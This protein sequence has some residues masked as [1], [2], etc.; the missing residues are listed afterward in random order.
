MGI[1]IGNQEDWKTG[2]AAIDKTTVPMMGASMFMGLTD[3]VITN[4]KPG[5]DLPLNGKHWAKAR[6]A[7]SPRPAYYA[8]KWVNAKISAFYSVKKLDL[9]KNI[10]A[11]QFETPNGSVWVLWYDDEKLY[12]PGE[13]PPS[14][15]V[16]L[17]FNAGRAILTRTPSEM[18]KSEP[19][20]QV[21]D[22]TQ[23]G[24]SVS[25]DAVPVFIQVE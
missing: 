1:N 22:A 4:N 24:L 6:Q 5:G 12:L 11:Y 23:G 7:R 9:G 21:L 3:T 15:D 17:P 20:T 16:T 19:E 2:A 8:F 25:L 13:T 10:W 14:V 18:G